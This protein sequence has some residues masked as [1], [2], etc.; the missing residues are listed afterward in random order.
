M[1]AATVQF[2][3]EGFIKLLT[4]DWSMGIVLAS[5]WSKQICTGRTKTAGY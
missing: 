3:D 1:I 5:Y 4:P 2:S